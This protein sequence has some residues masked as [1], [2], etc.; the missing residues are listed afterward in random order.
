M[1]G[2]HCTIFTKKKG[3]KTANNAK[4][5]A[6]Q[7][8]SYLKAH[9]LKGKRQYNFTTHSNFK[10]RAFFSWLMGNSK[11]YL[12]ETQMAHQRLQA[13]PC[14]GESDHFAAIPLTH[15]LPFSF[16]PYLWG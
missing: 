12:L 5:V 2:F 1:T 4:S 14:D 7:S 13:R 8:S 16:I 15:P 6:S 11:A 10:G 3:N 9:A